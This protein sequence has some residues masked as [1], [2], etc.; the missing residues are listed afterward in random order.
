MKKFLILVAVVSVFSCSTLVARA[1]ETPQNTADHNAL[2]AMLIDAEKAINAHQI[3]GIVK[4]LDPNVNVIF[5]NAE[6]A[7]G[8]PA[9]QAFYT[10]MFDKNNPVLKDFS[11]KAS[12]DVLSEIYGNT[13]VAYGTTLDHYTFAAGMTMDLTSKWSATLVK[14]NG[15]WKVVS[16]QFTSNLFDNPLL[17]KATASAKYFGIGGLIVGLILG[18]IL[19]KILRKKK[20]Y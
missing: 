9:V 1:Q 15:Q 10:R 11:T 4:Y 12:A 14:E 20:K 16:L 19:V 6:V 3:D 7:D 13:A 18:F 2:R 5:Q 8:V 17:S